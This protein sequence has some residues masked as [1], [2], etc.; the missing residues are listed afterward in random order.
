MITSIIR[1]NNNLTFQKFLDRELEKK[2]VRTKHKTIRRAEEASKVGFN[3][4]QFERK[5]NSIKTGETQINTIKRMIKTEN[6]LKGI[7]AYMKKVTTMAGDGPRNDTQNQSNQVYEELTK[8]EFKEMKEMN[9]QIAIMHKNYKPSYC[10]YTGSKAEFNFSQVMEKGVDLEK[11]Y[12]LDKLQTEFSEMEDV[13]IE[14]AENA[15]ELKCNTYNKKL[16]E[17]SHPEKMRKLSASKAKRMKVI[18]ALFKFLGIVKHQKIDMDTL[19]G[20]NPFPNKPFVSKNSKDFM[21]AVKTSDME[22]V[23]I[24][25]KGNRFLVNEF[26]FV[27]D[28]YRLEVVEPPFRINKILIIINEILT[29]RNTIL[30]STGPVF[31]AITGW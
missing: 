11:N 10:P 23:K 26:D 14:K 20:K 19:I 31:E 24:F 3:H 1:Q 28:N 12:N 18:Q 9:R 25:L 30:P 17:I 16:Y 7:T 2:D 29:P 8:Y 21:R 5:L 4:A 6:H 13:L 15:M 27:S 22:S